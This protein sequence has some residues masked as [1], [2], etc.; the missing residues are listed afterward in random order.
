LSKQKGGAG[1]GLSSGKH[2]GLI[3]E[4]GKAGEFWQSRGLA[5]IKRGGEKTKILL[6]GEIGLIDKQSVGPANLL[7]DEAKTGVEN[8]CEGG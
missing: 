7:M 8:K 5:F 6:Q 1:G 2:R 3:K 4:G